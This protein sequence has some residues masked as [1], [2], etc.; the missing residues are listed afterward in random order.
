MSRFV[1]WSYYRS[2]DAGSA[3]FKA[4]HGLPTLNRREAI[5]FLGFA[6]EVAE[7]GDQV[8]KA[9]LADL[10]IRRIKE[11]DSTFFAH[12]AEALER[13]QKELSE[14]DDTLGS[15]VERKVF[16]KFCELYIN[17]GKLPTKAAVRK[18]CGLGGA[19]RD[20]SS[21]LKLVSPAF[22]VLGLSGLPEG[23]GGRA[24]RTAA[25]KALISGHHP[26]KDINPA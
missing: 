25:L 7:N 15:K 3:R 17:D 20:E 10:M 24:K 5:D 6:N 4:V 12:I 19:G 11:A 14:S 2:P 8:G 22:T 23:R 9:L 18:G 13:P 21:A 26:E 16:L 1:F